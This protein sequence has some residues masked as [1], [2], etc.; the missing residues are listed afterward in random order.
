[1]SD[2]VELL[3]MGGVLMVPILAFSVVSFAVFFERL[4][5]LQT[6]R[7]IPRDFVSLINRKVKA[8]KTEEAK[9]LCEGNRAAVSAVLASGL[10]FA[11]QPREALK[12]AFEEVGRIEVAHLSRFVEVMGTI[13]AVTPLL[14]L[15]GTVVGM[16]DVFQTVVEEAGSAAGPVNPASLAGGIWAALVTTAAGL[17]A[18]IPAFIGYKFLLA[19]VD[20]LA[21]EME[22]VCLSLLDLLTEP[23][24]EAQP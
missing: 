14:G 12:A 20:T 5:S 2:L 23:E 4:F 16:I 3:Q 19:R 24:G 21:I 18:A 6:Q 11:N 9:T 8:G 7:V 1:M 15:L 17:S 22:E 13:A 10:R